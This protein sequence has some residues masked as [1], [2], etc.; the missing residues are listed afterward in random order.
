MN[1]SNRIPQHT[2]GFPGNAGT[3]SVVT[4]PQ[5]TRAGSTANTD[6]TVANLELGQNPIWIMAIA[7]GVF[8][9]FAAILMTF[10]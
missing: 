1:S 6:A 7:L 3:T 4:A 10:G 8:C 2:V 5:H 9:A